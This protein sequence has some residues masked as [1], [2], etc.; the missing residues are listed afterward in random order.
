MWSCVK[1]DLVINEKSAAK[2]PLKAISKYSFRNTFYVS[3][4]ITE[5]NVLTESDTVF[6][7]EHDT[8][9]IS[10][11]SKSVERVETSLNLRLG[12]HR[13]LNTFTA[14]HLL[15][16][17]NSNKCK[18]YACTPSINRGGLP[19]FPDHLNT[20]DEHQLICIPL[21]GGAHFQRYIIDIDRSAIIHIDSLS[22]NK[23]ENH[24]SQKIENLYFESNSSVRYE[25]L[26]K[27]KK[28]FDSNSCGAW[29][30][31]GFASYVLNLPVP[32]ER[33]DAFEI[34]YSLIKYANNLS[35]KPDIPLPA[36][37][38]SQEISKEYWKAE[39]LIN[40]LLNDPQ[41]SE[42]FREKAIKGKRSNFFYIVNLGENSLHDINAGNN[43][44]YTQTRNTPTMF[45]CNGK[46]VRTIYKNVG[47]LYYNEKVSFNTYQKIYVSKEDVVTLHR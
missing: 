8:E 6:L 10:L 39:F 25:C 28:Q 34:A 46:N 31:A 19:Y 42:Y 21:C 33:N 38:N 26:F 17:L 23:S 40:T 4:F 22:N 45:Y 47:K 16:K 14:D 30:V 18:I 24:T 20:K 37:L 3:R 35:E 43:E 2:K 7:L 36:V 32:S 13:Q 29:L 9:A 27:V 1:S 44:T 15:W 41:K 11:S 12:K 5:K